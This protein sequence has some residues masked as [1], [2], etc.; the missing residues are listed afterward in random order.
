MLYYDVSDIVTLKKGHPCGENKWEIVR[1]GVDMKLRCLGCDREIWMP[2]RDFE[3][4]IRRIKD[5]D[6]FVS[7]IHY[8]P[9][10]L[11]D[12]D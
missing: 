10:G 9:Q 8:K 7:I 3:K 12:Q 5:G 2:R 11:E 6:K 1:K 4:R